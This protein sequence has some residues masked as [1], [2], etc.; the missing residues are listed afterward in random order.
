M[1]WGLAARG[2]ATDHKR[3]GPSECCAVAERH[4]R[5]PGSGTRPGPSGPRWVSQKAA[6]SELMR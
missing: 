4:L 3:V 2:P 1:D 6:L 5:E